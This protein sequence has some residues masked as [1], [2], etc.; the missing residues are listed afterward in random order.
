ML[1]QD[2]RY[3]VRTLGQR[4]G[5]TVV[6]LLILALGIGANTV[7]FSVVDAVLFSPLPYPDPERLVTIRDENPDKSLFDQ[8]PAPGNILD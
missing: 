5:F 7:V 2:V 4:P 3:A 1:M 6:V 8:E